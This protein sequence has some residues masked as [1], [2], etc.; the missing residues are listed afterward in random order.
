MS[1]KCR[2]QLK[3]NDIITLI[4]FPVLMSAG[5]LLFRFCSSRNA[6]GEFADL[7]PLLLRNPIFYLALGLYGCATI[8]WIWLLTR[9]SLATAYPFAALA[10]AMVPVLEVI[11]FRTHLSAGYWI[12]LVLMISG[13][14]IIVK[15]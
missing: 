3:I 14:I 2:M 12:G 11:F 15:S 13:L 1:K 9:Y 5:Q 10:V 6:V 8:L 7:L 4:S